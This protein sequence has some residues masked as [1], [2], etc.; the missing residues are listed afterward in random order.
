MVTRIR[1]TLILALLLTAGSAQAQPTWPQSFDLKSS[2]TAHYS[3]AVPRP[4][5]IVVTVQWTG[6]PLTIQLTRPDGQKI[7]ANVGVSPG[8]LAALVTTS[9]VAKG[10]P[11]QL[12][13]QPTFQRVP[14]PKPGQPPRPDPN[15]FLSAKGTVSVQFPPLKLSVED[16]RGLVPVR[17]PPKSEINLR[18][19]PPPPP[20]PT[21]VISGLSKNQGQPGD[22]VT[23]SGSGF[24]SSMDAVTLVLASGREEGVYTTSWSDTSIRGKV[25]ALANYSLDHYGDAKFYVKKGSLVSGPANFRVNPIIVT[26]RMEMAFILVSGAGDNQLKPGAPPLLTGPDTNQGQFVSRSWGI[27]GERGD[28]FFLLTKKLVNGW[29]VVSAHLEGRSSNTPV[30]H[31]GNA[32]ASIT[33]SHPGTNLPY[34]KVHFF[35]EAYAS[36]AYSLVIEITGPKGTIALEGT[37]APF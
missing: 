36:L 3:F 26:R 18:L 15:R 14:P 6:S 1:T 31:T 9:D 28:D 7:P 30:A 4:G 2:D 37:S 32:S 35:G 16:R 10:S 20:I 25:P 17:T 5:E 34:V 33:E 8:T 27:T 29:K 19:P 11:W 12:D 21:P 24:G 23:I 22:E 13:L